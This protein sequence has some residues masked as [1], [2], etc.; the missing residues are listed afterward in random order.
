MEVMDSKV[1]A[2]LVNE[3]GWEKSF[4]LEE[5]AHILGS[6]ENARIRL[7]AASGIAPHNL[8]I[9]NNEGETNLRLVNLSPEEM[10]LENSTQKWV[11][12]PGE[13]RDVFGGETL[14][15]G[16]Y[17]LRFQIT[18]QYIQKQVV[19]EENQKVMG[20]RLELSGQVLRPGDTL[21]GTLY[22]RNLGSEACQFEVELTGLPSSCYEITPPPLIHAGGEE[23]TQIRIFHHRV[24]P[25]AGY[26]P[27]TLRLSAPTVYPGREITL[28]QMLKV[29]P[30][31]E[32]SFS[33]GEAE[34]LAVTAPLEPVQ[35]PED[36]TEAPVMFPE[37][38]LE[39][40][41]PVQ[42]TLSEPS[43]PVVPPIGETPAP[44]PSALEAVEMPPVVIRPKRPD[45]SSVKVM[46]ANAGQFLKDKDQS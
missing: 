45:L 26:V 41:E 29:L 24:T 31:Y 28:K 39:E 43:A 37:D 35:P 6:A 23:S 11:L 14:H 36:S 46:K 1:T 10:L 9:V 16:A 20:L 33:F 8:Q 22:L 2:I 3:E 32:H 4:Q 19:K 27:I 44:E 15:V 40:S 30:C 18:K 17:V 25:V 13:F 5:G 42:T 12:S 21:L 38:T 34:E 7:S